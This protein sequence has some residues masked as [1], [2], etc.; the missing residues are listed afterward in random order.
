L[1]RQNLAVTVDEL[2]HAQDVNRA[3]EATIVQREATITDLRTLNERNAVACVNLIKSLN[4]ANARCAEYKNQLRASGIPLPEPPYFL[5]VLDDGS[6][7]GP[8]GRN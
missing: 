5:A 6:V 7:A 8:F 4:G 1:L 2:R 3:L